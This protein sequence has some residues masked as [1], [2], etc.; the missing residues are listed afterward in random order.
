MKTTLTLALIGLSPI[1]GAQLAPGTNAP[2]SA[3]MLEVNKEWRT[4]DPAPEGGDRIVRFGN[5]AERIATHLRMVRQ[6]LIERTPEGLDAS[7]MN[8]RTTL[9]DDLLEY[10]D[11]GSF[12]QN[13]VLPWR[14]PVFIDPH[15]TACAVGQLMIASGDRALAEHVRKEMNLAYVHDIDLPEVATW[16]DAH[17][18]TADELAWIQP[19]YSPNHEWLP[20]G[21]G[22]DGEV[23]TLLKLANGDL[24]VAG[25]YTT[26]GSTACTHVALWN[27]SSYQAMGGGVDGWITCAIEFGGELYLGGSFSAGYADLA[28][29]D[30]SNWGYENAFNGNTVRVND[31]HVFNGSLYAAGYGTGF[32][33]TAHQVLE[34]VGAYWLPTGSAWTEFNGD[35]LALNDHYG[36]LVCAGAFTE[37]GMFGGGPAMAHVA[38]FDGLGDWT[39]LA[40]GLD[41]TVNDLYSFQ[42]ALYAGGDMRVDSL[43]TFGLARL[44]DDV[45]TWDHLMPNQSGYID[46]F[47]GECRISTIHEGNGQLFVGGAFTMPGF[48]Y[49]GNNLMRFEG[50]PDIFSAWALNDGRVNDIAV[51]DGALVIGGQFVSDQGD[52]VPHVG[53]TDLSTGIGE[54]MGLPFTIAPNPVTDVLSIALGTAPSAGTR[55]TIV[56]ATGRSVL[57]PRRTITA[58]NT[59]DVRVLAPGT[60]IVRVQAGARV[61]VASFVKR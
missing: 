58:V 59:I 27:G 49:Y 22:A 15:G 5:D 39:Q 33:G 4:M 48:M 16:A 6:R 28:V 1:C 13:H 20:L 55:I 18:F 47:N 34:L 10:A 29:W 12:P 17:G 38:V 11:A 43:P 40:D 41:A 54:E 23:T 14:N 26:A 21:G 52:P 32:A 50:V 8:A 24:L 35:V 2:L 51:H 37:L 36:Q 3:H 44:G 19:G 61:S 53:R 45:A 7:R 60:Y 30:G 31:L 42:L 57:E 46:W 56:D 25:D 9:L